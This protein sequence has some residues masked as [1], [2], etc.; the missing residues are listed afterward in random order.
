MGLVLG[1][2]AS[3]ETEQFT[4]GFQ[5]FG[6]HAGLPLR[7]RGAERVTIKNAKCEPVGLS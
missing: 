1:L 5:S 6:N 4:S 2:K 7:H 3:K